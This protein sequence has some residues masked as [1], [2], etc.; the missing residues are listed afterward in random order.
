MVGFFHVPEGPK[1]IKYFYLLYFCKESF[2]VWCITTSKSNNSDKNSSTTTTTTTTSVSDLYIVELL[3]TLKK[4]KWI[5]DIRGEGVP[6]S[7]GSSGEGSED[8][9]LVWGMDCRPLT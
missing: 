6:E 7:G 8:Q 3:H 1:F 2:M 4:S 9:S 5:S